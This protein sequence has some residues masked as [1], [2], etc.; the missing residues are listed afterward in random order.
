MCGTSVV[1]TSIRS[2]R[3]CA[4]GRVSRPGTAA[5]PIP[6]QKSLFDKNNECGLPIG[7]LT[8][9]FWAN[10]YLNEL[11]Q[12]VKRQVKCRL[13]VRYVDDLILLHTDAAVLTHWRDALI[14]FVDERL[15][16][17]WREPEAIPQA[18]GRGV[19]FVGWNTFWS[20]RVPRRQTVRNCARRMSTFEEEHV[21]RRGMDRMVDLTASGP[22]FGHLSAA[23][24][25]YSG[26]L[27]H[28]S[29]W[30]RWRGMIE[31]HDWLAPLLAH[32]PDLG[33]RLVR[34]W[35]LGP[36][37]GMRFSRQYGRLIGKVDER[38]VVFCE[39]GRFV[40]FYGPQRERATTALRLV[41]VK[42][43][44]GGYAFSVG[45][46]RRLVAPSARSWP[47]GFLGRGG[48]DVARKPGDAKARR[49][50]TVRE[51]IAAGK[52]VVS[53]THTEKL[54]RR[55][56]RADEIERAIENG[57]IIEDYPDDPRG[58]S[59]LILGHA[60][61]RPIHVVCGRLE[62]DEILIV[63]AYQPDAD[64]WEPGW[65]KRRR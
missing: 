33:W 12:F 39:V 42:I 1:T 61:E 18:V 55:R 45:F 48:D 8:S 28:G 7:N 53:F 36:L 21:Q 31:R 57:E 47:F 62:A 37:V 26:H 17:R 60:G 15:R 13:Y 16:L 30:R 49:L 58:P 9:Q 3:I 54:R 51:R 41:R 24:A 22:G 32:G 4:T 10:V 23:L 56:I 40:E 38:T 34:R 29:S 6:R 14:A 43:G 59:C 52:Y 50:G 64:E 25:S 27:R 35:P 19:D 46:P 20:H 5:Y 2:A 11:D 44:R 65:A 63:T